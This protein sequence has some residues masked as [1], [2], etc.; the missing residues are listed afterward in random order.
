MK[1]LHCLLSLIMA[2]CLLIS[3]KG[4]AAAPGMDFFSLF[5][6]HGSVM[7]VINAESGIIEFANEAAREFY[8]FPGE[9]LIGMNIDQI[10]TL[11]PEEVARE[12]QAAAR[13]ERNYFEFRHR[14]HNGEVRKVEVYSYPV[15]LSGE[16]FLYSIIV[17]ITYRLALYETRNRAISVAAL[18]LGIFFVAV[19]GFSLHLRKVVRRETR[20]AAVHAASERQYRQMLSHVPGMVYRCLF[21]RQWTM[22]YASPGALELTGYSPDELFM[23][24]VA[25]FNDLI[26]PDFREALWEKWNKVMREGGIFTEEYKITARDGLKKWVWE[27]GSLIYDQTGQLSIV[28]IVSDITEQK[29]NLSLLQKSE[30]KLM[31]TLLSVGDGFISTDNQGQIEFLNPVAENM[32]GWAAV[33]ARGRNFS[34][35]FDIF[36]EYSREKAECPVSLALASGEVVTLAN[37]TK[38]R[39][40]DG[41]ERII[42]DTAAP[43]RDTS[44]K[45]LGAVVVFRDCTAAKDRQREIEHISFHDYLTGLYNRRFFEEELR[46]LDTERNLPISLI[47][48]D[49]NGLKTINDAFGHKAGDELLRKTGAI[50]RREFRG[51]DITARVG[52]DEFVILLLKTD[53]A[54]AERLAQRLKEAVEQEKVVDIPISI[55]L[56]WDTKMVSSENIKD[57]LKSA[58]DFMYKKKIAEN[59]SNRS[60]VIGAILNT[61]LIKSPVEEEHARRVGKYSQMIGEAMG[62]KSGEINELIL[63]AQVHD[64]GKIAID[65]SMLMNPGLLTHD[66]VKEMSRHPEIGYRLLSTSTEYHSVAESILTH[67]ERWDGTGYPQGIKG[68]AIPLMARIIAVAD[69]FD[70]MTGGRPYRPARSDGEALDEIRRCS[71]THFDPKVARCFVEKVMKMRWKE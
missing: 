28:G 41:S 9:T 36:N 23:N 21:D 19:T 48:L 30:A 49:V 40:R 51:D 1:L 66:E 34:E 67:H 15:I 55:S 53:N 62:I 39:S 26:E 65:Y 47:I 16:P 42:E 17:D 35:V 58:E 57:V 11:S 68:D 71:G 10:N 38:L 50:L 31:A 61:L 5:N 25:S 13:E 70:A 64:I 3:A 29:N 33:E 46:R 56:G 18:T 32:T 12:R 69:A 8:G 63:A 14:L 20:H 60:R 44:G 59:A 54:G 7:L 27:R 52:G 4:A 43:I 22:L 2:L 37:H 6:N 45:M 24:K